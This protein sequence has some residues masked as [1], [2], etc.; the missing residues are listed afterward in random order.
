[1]YKV[2]ELLNTEIGSL[3]PI[4]AVCQLTTGEKYQ[5]TIEKDETCKLMQC[6]EFEDKNSKELFESDYVSRVVISG[7]N[8]TDECKFQYDY[9]NTVWWQESRSCFCLGSDLLEKWPE[10]ITKGHIL[11]IIGNIYENPELLTL[12]GEQQL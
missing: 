7:D 8:I 10:W 3:S 5:F 12:Y 9:R 1:M 4:I 11:T 6:T 2:E